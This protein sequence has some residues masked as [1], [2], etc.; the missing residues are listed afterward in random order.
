MYQVS[1]LDEYGR[2]LASNVV[3][4]IGTAFRVGHNAVEGT[5]WP[6]VT[7]YQVTKVEG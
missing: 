7:S 5:V 4:G 1:L 3:T 6:T 2:V